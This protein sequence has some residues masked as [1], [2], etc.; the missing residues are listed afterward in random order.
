[1]T[2]LRMS[3]NDRHLLGYSGTDDFSGHDYLG[4]HIIHLPSYHQNGAQ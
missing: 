3:Q 1:M 4:R 2:L